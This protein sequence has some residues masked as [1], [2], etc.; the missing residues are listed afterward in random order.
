MSTRIKQPDIGRVGL[1][2]AGGGARG[3]YEAGALSVLMP[4]LGSEGAAPTILSGTSAG[5]L[6]VV[7]LAGLAHFGWE[8]AAAD[9][10][11]I[12]SSVRFGDV[13]DLST[14][15]LGD[16]VAFATQFLTQQ[17]RLTSLLDTRKLRSTLAD[18]LP[19]AAMHDNIRSGLIDA[20]AVT[21]TAESTGG[22]VVFVEKNASVPLPPF[23]PDRNI[24]YVETQL[25]V[26]HVLA[27]AAV[28]V[29][30]R[31]VA[32]SHPNDTYVDGGVRLNTPLKPAIALGSQRLAVVATHP[33]TWPAPASREKEDPKADVFTG[34]ALVLR[35]LLADRMI[36]DLRTLATVNELLPGNRQ[37]RYRTIPF[38]FAGPQPDQSG[39]LAALADTCF[40]S[41]DSVVDQFQHRDIRQLRRLLGGS[42]GARGELLTFLLFDACFTGPAAALGATH[43]R[44]KAT[45]APGPNWLTT[46]DQI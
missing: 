4:R 21:T 17:G 25:T 7:G 33:A 35:S 2:L 18:L 13:A 14:S 5:A 19:F 20:V 31:P 44:G 15:L 24:S 3:A 36:E 1:A 9:L 10:V 27:S 12:W 29:A 11:Q 28:P 30:F 34:A 16:T 22:T 45:A 8:R 37:T 40:D 38:V 32:L 43:A 39:E 41:D 6:N 42:T 23:D 46:M 26:D